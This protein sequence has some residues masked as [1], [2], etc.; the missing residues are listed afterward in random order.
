MDVEAVT[1]PGAER[2]SWQDTVRA[3]AHALRAE[4][5]VAVTG[6]WGAG[7][8]TLLAGALDAAVEEGRT[9]VRVTCADG[10]QH[11]VFGGLAQLLSALPGAL[12]GTV[13]TGRATAVDQLLHRPVG[14]PAGREE[15]AA[16]RRAMADLLRAASAVD[17]AVDDVQWLDEAS[18]DVLGYVARTV[19][20]PGLAVLVSERTAGRPEVA[21]RL[22]GGHPV[23]VPASALDLALTAAVVARHGLP[24]RATSTV[25]RYCGGHRL[26][27]EIACAGLALRPTADEQD[28]P[29]AVV[30]AAQEWLATLSAPVRA[31]LLVAALARRPAVSLLERAGRIRADDH[32]RAA[33]AAGVLCD[34]RAGGVRFTA[35]ALADGVVG[36]AGQQ[37]RAEA[38]RSL[39]CAEADPVHAVRHRALSRPEAT[40]QCLAEDTAEA[41]G[42]ARADGERA[43]SAELFVLAAELTPVNRPGPRLTRFLTAAREAAAAGD[44]R[45]AR[46]AANAVAA[47]RPTPAQHVAAL[48]AV[49]DSHSQALAEAAGL[50]ERCRR[51]ASGDPQLLAAVELRAAIRANVSDSD[52]HEALRAARQ[53]AEL[54]RTAGRPVLEAAALTMRA[55]ME[56]V[57]NEG[58]STR[59]LDCALA[60]NV[61]AEA[62]GIG[63]S[64]QYLAARHAIFDDRLAEARSRLT[65]LLAVAEQH[66]QEEDLV[67][68]WRSLAEVEVRSGACAKALA[69]AGKA[70]DA[71]V[72]AGLSLGPACYTAALAQSAG[73]SF[74]SALRY[75]AH[76]ERAARE[77]GDVLHRKRNLWMT[78]AVRLHTGDIDGAVTAFARLSRTE[79]NRRPAD[80]SVF[81]WQPDAI[82]AFVAAGELTAAE[83]MIQVSPAAAHQDSATGAA[84][85]R[86]RALLLARAGET[87]HAVERLR[88]AAEVFRR[89]GLPLEE[90]RTHLVRGRILRAHRRQAA[91]R[92]AFQ[93]ARDLCAGA[94]ARPMLAIV[95]EHLDRLDGQGR[96]GGRGDGKTE[97]TDAEVRLADLV[98]RGATNQQAAQQMHISVKTVE[99]MLSRVYRKLQIRSRT[100]LSA[101]LMTHT[102]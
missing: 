7:R 42:R 39:A 77:E 66:G 15:I 89:D 27:T 5:R 102:G 93:D 22:L 45:L 10:D 30:Q 43:L 92:T 78:G 48:L 36:A 34:D 80:P 21:G 99:S 9:Q 60:L 81:R 50:L 74:A 55:R 24:H 70:L 3:A 2:L 75:A 69:W 86:A 46:R 16:A 49:V 56:R 84:W 13:R 6:V 23:H 83:N 29:G 40:D 28:L 65:V 1:G 54:A 94:R 90:A 8:T 38:H 100:Q 20:A 35:P 12:P 72:A 87:D 63:N 73:G 59:T 67:D 97:L 4:G 44:G 64:P 101:T 61:A 32:V 26:L 37:E 98:S 51:L 71:S 82:E 95:Q 88:A 53:A 47:S 62:D 18:A 19:A 52:P 58:D 76:G 31:T 25:F 79:D 68:I 14:G 85:T 33:V 17:I 41:A 96:S 57:L 11:Y 91:A